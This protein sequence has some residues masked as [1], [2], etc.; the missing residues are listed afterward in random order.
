MK[1]PKV[2]GIGFHKT[3]TK[4][5][6]LALEILGYRVTG[7]NG[8]WDE[9]IAKNALTIAHQKI[10]EYDAFQ[11]N[12][13][14]ILY[15]EIDNTYPESKFILTIRPPELWI[16]SVVNYFGT[17]STPMRQWIY[18]AGSPINNEQTYLDR[19]LKHNQKVMQYFS[20]R[21]DDLLVLSITEGDG[22]EKLCPFLEAE[23]PAISF[24]HENIFA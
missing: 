16:K 13:W 10:K 24:P 14:P 4:S 5:L 18:G 8:I 6:A 3:A 19:Y 23:L 20:N 1:S 12:P 15:K 9:N 2:F 11:D 17:E 22:W 7:P 21:P